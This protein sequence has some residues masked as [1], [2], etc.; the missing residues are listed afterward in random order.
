MEEHG[1]YAPR[2]PKRKEDRCPKSPDGHHCWHKV[3]L[4][5]KEQYFLGSTLSSPVEGL[6]CCYCGKEAPLFR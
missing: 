5:W 6:R 1:P 3:I 4:Y 2:E